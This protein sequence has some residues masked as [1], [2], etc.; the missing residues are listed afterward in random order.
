MKILGRILKFFF[1][2][3]VLLCIVFCLFV[4]YNF[5]QINI[6]N[7]KYSNVFGYTFFE[8]ATGSM[9]ETLQISDVIIVKITDDVSKD[10]IITFEKEEQ[11][12]THRVIEKN[13]DKIITKGDANN[14]ADKPIDK[15]NVIG[16]VVY[17]IPQM[18]VWIKVFS[19]VKVLFCIFI[20]LILLGLVFN[21]LS[22]K[23]EK[24]KRHAF[25]RFIKN[26]RGIRKNEE[27]K[28]KE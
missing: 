2:T 18:G 3:I 14:T 6:L 15:S 19:D 10:D 12:I 7:N 25:S 20:T 13:K 9:K 28:E 23:K 8:V 21:G 16:K 27:K 24:K 1:D 4:G 11:I 5:F 17:V 22:K 26:V